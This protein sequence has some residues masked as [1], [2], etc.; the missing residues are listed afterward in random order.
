MTRCHIPEG[1]SP[2]MFLFPR[3][4]MGEKS[5][6]RPK[7]APCFACAGTTFSSDQVSAGSVDV[8]T[9]CFSFIRQ[10]SVGGRLMVSGQRLAGRD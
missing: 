6:F 7:H 3:L 4:Y 10:T 1:H 2:Q 9:S 5:S 8:K